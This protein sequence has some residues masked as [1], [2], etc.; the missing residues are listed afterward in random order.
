MVKKQNQWEEL[1]KKTIF[2]KIFENHV[3]RQEL[4]LEHDVHAETYILFGQWDWKLINNV[5]CFGM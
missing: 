4:L 1:H 3:L 2:L 5:V